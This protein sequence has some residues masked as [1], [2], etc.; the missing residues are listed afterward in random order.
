MY[1][2]S[3]MGKYHYKCLPM[4]FF[5]SKDIFQQKINAQWWQITL[6][7]DPHIFHITNQNKLSVFLSDL[8]NLNEQLKHKT[9]QMPKINEM[10]LKLEGLKNDTSIDLN[11]TYYHIWLS[12]DASNLCTIILPLVNTCSGTYP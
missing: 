3:P 4:V 9:N 11:M 8:R 12:E 7:V 10:M 1:N 6:N 5:N 2:H